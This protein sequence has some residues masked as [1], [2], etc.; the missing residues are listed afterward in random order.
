MESAPS[1][2]ILDPMSQENV[3]LAR[4]GMDA[5][6]RRDRAAWIALCDPALENHPPLDW[7]EAAV[8]RGAEAVWDFLVGLQEGWGQ[9]EY[10]WAEVIDA[11]DDRIV[12]RQRAELRG[13][14]S[15]AGVVFSYW[16]VVTLRDGKSLRFEWFADRSEA[17][18]AAAPGIARE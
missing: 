11:G 3:E 8:V 14:A 13:D 9:A 5:F 17:L 7:P 18:A 10:E 6:N 15:G 12:G 1:S 2:G 4:A 16:L